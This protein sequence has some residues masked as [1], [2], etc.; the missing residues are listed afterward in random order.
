MHRNRFRNSRIL[1]NAATRQGPHSGE[2]SYKTVAGPG[3]EPGR[4]PYEGLLAATPPANQYLGSGSNRRNL[5]LFRQALY[6]LS[7]P[8]KSEINQAPEVGIEPTFSGSEPDVLPLNYP[9]VIRPTLRKK[10]TAHAERGTTLRNQNHSLG[11]WGHFEISPRALH[12]GRRIR[13]FTSS[14]KG[15]QPTISRSPSVSEG[16][17]QRAKGKSKKGE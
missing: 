12:S 16:K 5:L 14:F 3:I 8:G 6:Q 9:G 1:A 7:Y 10:K 11:A 17:R 15:C 4:E 13:T 2:C